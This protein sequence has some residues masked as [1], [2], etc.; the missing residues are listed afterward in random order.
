MNVPAIQRKRLR[1]L[2]ISR[3]FLGAFLVFCAQFVFTVE[4]VVF[5]AL[6]ALISTLS[7]FYVIWLLS[8]KSLELLAM[9]QVVCDLILESILIY[10]TGGVDSLF[11][12]IYVLT[13]LSASLVL[14]PKASFLAA[15]G[16]A[17]CF[18]ATI[19]SVFLEWTPPRNAFFPQPLIGNPHD[20]IYVFYASY[21]QVTV[22]LLVAV[23]AYFFSRMI[24]KLEEKMKVQERL[25]LLGQVASN[26]AHEIRNPLTSIS[27]SVELIAKQL[28]SQLSEK[29]RKLL[30]AVVDES[31]RIN[32][33][34]NGILDYARLPELRFEKIALEPFLDDVL[35][36]MRH[37]EAFDS[38]VQVDAPYRGKSIM[39]HAD[40]EY[41][42]QVF[43]NLITNAF[44]AMPDGGVLS[45]DCHVARQGVVVS[46]QDTGEGL[47]RE[48]VKSLFLP[49]KTTKERGTGLGMAQA[50][51]IVSQHG[52]KILVHSHKHQGTKV[53]VIFPTLE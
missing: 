20:A 18:I 39:I 37:Q 5:Y 48:I 28:N 3:L 1:T 26:I 42:K 7:I 15:V 32:R 13:I 11:G 41:L 33:I 8:G 40:P 30:N 16:S 21:V 10:Y 2:I 36:L 31:S 25:V 22:F 27:G 43:I 29:Q 6:I 50:Y 4:A 44:E 19:L 45:V 35:L 23:L 46:I 24:Q 34:F 38:K 9:V 52:G 51:K 53:E 49:F 14:S 17:I 12:S 47:D